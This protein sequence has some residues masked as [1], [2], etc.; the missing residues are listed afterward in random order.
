[1]VPVVRQTDPAFLNKV[2]NHEDVR[3]WLGGDLSQPIDLTP[4]IA[5]PRNYAFAGEHGGILF[6]H[7]TPGVYEAHT[8]VLPDGRGAWTMEMVLSCLHEMFCGSDAIEVV[9]R[10]PEGN[11]AARALVGRLNKVVRVTELMRRDTWMEAGRARPCEFFS[12]TIQEW[13]KTAPELVEAGQRFHAEIE[14]EFRR[15]NRRRKDHPDD[16]VHDR[17]AGVAYEMARRGLPLKAQLFYNRWAI[18]ACYAPLRVERVDPVV[19]D[20]GDCHVLV[21]DGVFEV[22]PYN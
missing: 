5:D 3:P 20:I 9:T 11:I 10:V 18:L 16:E 4:N 8:Q 17:Y 7:I 15:L 12:L 14:A 22:L 1:M 19:I 21:R 13:M 6:Q 2:V